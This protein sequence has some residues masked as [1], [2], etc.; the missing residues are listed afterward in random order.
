[1]KGL[2]VWCGR[3]V[4]TAGVAAVMAGMAC[5][6]AVAQEAVGGGS[7]TEAVQRQPSSDTTP[8]SLSADELDT[9]VVG[10]FSY[11]GETV[12]ITARQA[13]EDSVSLA[14]RLNDDGTYSAPTADM[15][16]SCARNAILNRMVQEAGI[17]VTT[18]ELALY[19][20][21]TLGTSDMATIARYYGMDEEQATRILA[22]AAAVVKLRDATVG[23]I[24]AAPVPPVAP[25]DAADAPTADYAAYILELV[26]DDWDAQANA[27]ANA[28]SVYCQ[29]LEDAQFDGETATY[30]AAQLAYYV[31]YSLYQQDAASQ[32]AAW[33]AYA[34]QYLGDASVQI[35][36]LR[37]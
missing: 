2:M 37:S 25:E 19:A 33:T 21:Q 23:S 13:I 7:P 1:M 26:G 4:A 14:S 3:A 36:T 6:P 30:Q 12:E 17:E 29:A 28:D 11:G 20:E 8:A 31:A 32:R 5:M 24:G 27:W 15:V 18:D 10:S 16:L 9:V 35:Y 34:N 22:D